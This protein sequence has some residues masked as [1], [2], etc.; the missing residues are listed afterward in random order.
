MSQRR[1]KAIV[2]DLDD[3]LYPECQFVVSGCRAV[4][5]YL[6]RIYGLQLFDDFLECY[7]SGVRANLFL[8]VLQ[9]YFKQVEPFLIQR[10]AEI[11]RCHFPSLELYPDA[12]VGLALLPGK[13]IFSGLMT[14]GFGCVQK[15]KVEALNLRNLVDSVVYA[16]DLGGEEFWKPSAEPFHILAIQMDIEP[17][18]MIYV[19]DNPLVDFLAPRRLGMGTVQIVRP[20]TDHAR[21]TPPT[22]EHHPHLRIQ[23]LECILDAWRELEKIVPL[24][25]HASGG[26]AAHAPETD[27]ESSKRSRKKA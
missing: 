17:H 16:D 24:P 25:A 3:T 4:S 2:F 6:K 9:R 27:H 15:N 5:S 13:G 12:R 26:P 14:D 18:Q 7:R 19:G 21:D 23:S 20:D 11:Y 1:F 8:E 10:L 22:P